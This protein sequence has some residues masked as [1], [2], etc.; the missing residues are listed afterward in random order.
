MR[1][2]AIR[3]C[4]TRRVRSVAS[5]QKRLT[6]LFITALAALIA[7][8]MLTDQASAALPESCQD[9]LDANPLATDGDYTKS[10]HSH[11]YTWKN[12]A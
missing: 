3:L 7:L 11:P 6:L 1:P 2:A 5:I 9:I 10:P 8:M 4:P 12:V